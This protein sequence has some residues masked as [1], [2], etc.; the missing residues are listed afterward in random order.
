MIL[1]TG[2]LLILDTLPY[3][4]TTQWHGTDAAYAR[5]KPLQS[6]TLIPSFAPLL[7]SSILSPNKSHLP[8]CLHILCGEKHL[9]IN[10]G[11]ANTSYKYIV[12]TSHFRCCYNC[13]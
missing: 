5:Q 10:N 11:F 2:G 7:F 4:T 8:L 3:G 6:H 1:L 12:H 13:N 9:Y